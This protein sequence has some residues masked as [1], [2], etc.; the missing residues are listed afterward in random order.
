MPDLFDTAIIARHQRAISR[1]FEEHPDWEFD[2][3]RFGD[4][5]REYLKEEYAGELLREALAEEIE[6]RRERL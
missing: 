2:P 1:I 4:C 6:E 3:D 5:F